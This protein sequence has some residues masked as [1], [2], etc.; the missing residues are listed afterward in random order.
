M[1]SETDEFELLLE[2]ILPGFEQYYS[3]YKTDV[4]SPFVCHAEFKSHNEQYLL[5]KAAKIADID[6]SDYVYFACTEELTDE[7]LNEFSTAAWNYGLSKVHPYYGHR[8]SDV[9]LIILAG[10]FSENAA[11]A[12]KKSKNYK[13]YKFGFFGWSSFRLA[14]LNASSGK[15]VCNYRGQDLKK[16]LETAAVRAGITAQ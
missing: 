7:V 4:P 1:A 8:N 2:K 3:I 13:S 6:S 5:V 16:L 10:K 9:T 14:V 12:I 15:A 11:K